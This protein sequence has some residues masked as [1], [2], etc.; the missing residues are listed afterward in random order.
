[1]VLI[2]NQVEC[3]D[4]LIGANLIGL[5]LQAAFGGS[6]G[7]KKSAYT[8][9]AFGQGSTYSECEPRDFLPKSARDR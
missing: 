7:E 6:H 2:Y 4:K 3:L 1:M 5:R 8:L 9:L